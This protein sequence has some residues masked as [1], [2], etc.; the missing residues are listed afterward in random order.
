LKREAKVQQYIILKKIT[1]QIYGQ[2]NNIGDTYAKK[3]LNELIEKNIIKRV[4]KE[5]DTYYY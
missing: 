5:K 3:E 4:G 2:I 1:R